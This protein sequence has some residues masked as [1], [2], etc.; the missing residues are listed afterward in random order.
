MTKLVPEEEIAVALGDLM[1]HGN[2]RSSPEV[3]HR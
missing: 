2:A 1:V 3:A